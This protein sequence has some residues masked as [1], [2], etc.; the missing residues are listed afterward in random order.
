MTGVKILALHGDMLISP[1][2]RRPWPTARMERSHDYHG[3]YAYAAMADAMEKYWDEETILSDVEPD[4]DVQVYDSGWHAD[5]A[6]ITRIYLPLRR[7]HLRDSLL[8]RYRVPVEPLSRIASRTE[9]R[10]LRLW[11][12][13]H[14]ADDMMMLMPANAG[15]SLVA[16]IRRV[17]WR[18]GMADASP[19]LPALYDPA[20]ARIAAEQARRRAQSARDRAA[21]AEKRAAAAAAAE[22][23]AQE[24]ARALDALRPHLPLHVGY[25][26]QTVSG[27][28]WRRR[29]VYGAARGVI[30]LSPDGSAVRCRT[31]R[32]PARYYDDA[33]LA[34]QDIAA[35]GL[36]TISTCPRAKLSLAECIRLKEEA[37]R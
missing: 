30:S 15:P 27:P 4:G 37:R 25:V 12:A 14:Y 23:L 11:M 13:T 32:R 6:T 20:Q 17:Q 33:D 18:H 22:K 35:W 8:A 3:V 1:H 34:A 2:T 29:A 21:A 26:D 36:I 19:H 10:D 7:W 9:I 5:A 28:R 31:Y 24:Y 16:S